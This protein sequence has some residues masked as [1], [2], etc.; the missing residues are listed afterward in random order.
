MHYDVKNMRS[1]V[2]EH[3]TCGTDSKRAVYYTTM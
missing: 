1:Q 2:F 3:T